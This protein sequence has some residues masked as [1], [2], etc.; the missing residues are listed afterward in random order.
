MVSVSVDYLSRYLSWKIGDEVSDCMSLD[1]TYMA[2]WSRN[3]AFMF[4]LFSFLSVCSFFPI[5]HLALH[6][7]DR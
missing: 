6:Y 2:K 7:I 1:R 5:Y 3:L 4:I